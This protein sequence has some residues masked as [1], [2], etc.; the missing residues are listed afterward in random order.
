MKPEQEIGKATL[1]FFDLETTGLVSRRDAICEISAIKVQAGNIKAKFDT[2]LNPRQPIPPAAYK[3]HNISDEDVK[4]AP[5]FEEVIDSFLHFINRSTILGYNVLF[6]LS[7]LNYNLQRIRYPRL[8]LPFIDV[9]TMARRIFPGLKSYNLQS[10]VNYFNLKSGRFHR[11]LDDAQA[12]YRVFSKIVSFLEEKGVRKHSDYIRMFGGIRQRR[13][14]D[15]QQ[16]LIDEA[17]RLKLKLR[18]KYFSHYRREVIERV[19]MPLAQRNR[20][21]A[22]YLESR[23]IYKDTVI[24]FKLNNILDIK[25]V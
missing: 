5:Y 2:L 21:R 15:S 8:Q 12:T 9:L 3:I 13:K 20:Q 17:I 24:S 4:K 6:D 1:V 22:V 10:M 18:I 14:Y 23:W 7:F 25:V 11:A 19:V 16:A